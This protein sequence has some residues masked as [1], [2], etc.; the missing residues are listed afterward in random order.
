MELLSLSQIMKKT[1][2]LN[3]LLKELSI[4]LNKKKVRI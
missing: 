2:Y 4:T 3:K 1:L